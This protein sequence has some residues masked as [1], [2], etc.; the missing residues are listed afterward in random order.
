MRNLLIAAAALAIATP[1]AAQPPARHLQDEEVAPP[2]PSA[3]EI[4]ELTGVLEGLVG[5][6]LDIPIG[7]IV[8]AV[9]PAGRGRYRR[10]DTLRDLSDDPHIEHRLRD[11]IR[12]TSA[13]LG[14]IAEAMTAVTPVLR[15]SIEDVRRRMEQAIEGR[16][17]G[18]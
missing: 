10:S 6:L 4:G 13:G 9:D 1:A 8:A 12:G 7:P 5:A 11:S 18:D 15:R 3:R 14:A 16:P 17:Y 2:L